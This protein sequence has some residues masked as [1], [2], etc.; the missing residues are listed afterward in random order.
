M[1]IKKTMSEKA[2]KANQENGRKSKGPINVDAVAQNARKHGLQSKHLVFRNEQEQQ[3]FEALE[4]DLM[5]EYH[6]VG[7]TAWEIVHE[8]AF[9]F[10]KKSEANG[11]ELQE[12]AH[13]NKA[14]AAILKTL[15]ENHDPG[16]LPLFT[17]QNGSQS[18][19]GLGWDCEELVIRTGNSKSELVEAGPLG[20][21][22]D[23]AGHVLI[24]AKMNTSLNTILRYQ[25]AAKHDL[26][27]TIKLLRDCSPSRRSPNGVVSGNRKKRGRR[28]RRTTRRTES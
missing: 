16:Q 7:Q 11:W 15:A 23:K 8:L 28:I 21:R 4:A 19:A 14:S 6:P 17:E 18:A 3:E 9:C 27:D 12:L 24:E 5:D 2:L 10:W 22:K 26:R 1:K 20:D 25:A 13:R